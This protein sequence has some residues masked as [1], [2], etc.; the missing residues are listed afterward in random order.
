MRPSYLIL[1]ALMSATL[2]CAT[3]TA[4]PLEWDTSGD[5]VVI[6][7]TC[8][9]G[10]VPT[11]FYDNAIAPVRLWGDGRLVWLEYAGSERRVLESRLSPDD[12]RA[13]LT[14]VVEAGYFG[15]PRDFE[16][17]NV[18]YDGIDCRLNV[19]L[20]S[21]DKVVWVRAGA[22]TPEAYN[23]LVEWLTGGA[24]AT[25]QEV[26]PARGWLR[27]LPTGL[28]EA[29]PAFVWPAEGIDGVRLVDAA[30]A[31]PVEGEALTTAWRI[32]NAD[33]FALV[34]S[35]GAMYTLIV[36]VEGVTDRWPGAP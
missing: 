3:L 2:A 9:G 30:Q 6:E 32:I 20:D 5:H 10:L 35:D 24:G 22:E 8:V 7:Y 18:I 15:W 21:Q 34:E 17:T 1:T 12:M 31:V 28:T 26:M 14:Q 4:P 13:V 29:V 16:S 27:A 23:D 11:G 25:G 33:R 19:S 36:Q